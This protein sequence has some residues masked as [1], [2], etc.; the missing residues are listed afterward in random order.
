MTLNAVIALILRFF[1]RT[2]QI[3]WPITSISQWLKIEI[4]SPSSSLLLLAKSITHPAVRSLWDGWASSLHLHL[5]FF[6]HILY[7]EYKWLSLQKAGIYLHTKFR[8]DITIHDWDK[9]LPV[10]ENGRRPYWN[11]TS[12]FDFDLRVVVVMSFCIYLPNF[13]VI[14]TS[15]AELWRHRFLSRCMECRRGLAMRILS[16]R[17]SVSLSVCSTRD[18]WQNGRKIGPDCYIIWKII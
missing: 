9:L 18:L 13:V 1:H 5:Q 15:A 16:V 11:S 7:Y 17:P 8:W 2:R 6:Y 12:N 14:G 4:L 10:W 3:F